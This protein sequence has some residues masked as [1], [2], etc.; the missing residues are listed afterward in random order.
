MKI[1]IGSGRTVVVAMFIAW[2]ALIPNPRYRR[3]SDT[4][5]VV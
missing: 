1:A 2:H 4:L 3:F 5:I